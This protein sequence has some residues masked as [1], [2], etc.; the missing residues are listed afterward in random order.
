VNRN[1]TEN[2]GALMINAPLVFS[3][4]NATTLSQFKSLVNPSFP[5]LPPIDH[6]P[7]EAESRRRD[8]YYYHPQPKTSRDAAAAARPRSS[9][10]K[11]CRAHRQTTPCDQT[12]KTSLQKTPDLKSMIFNIIEEVRSK[13]NSKFLLFP[14]LPEAMDHHRLRASLG[15]THP[16][17]SWGTTCVFGSIHMNL[18]LVDMKRKLC[19]T[20]KSSKTQSKPLN[21]YLYLKAHFRWYLVSKFVGINLVSFEAN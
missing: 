1:A 4:C 17:K 19:K 14:E 20:C 2:A 10:S 5:Q 9:L 3:S 16:Q 11:S 8:L 15:N 6:Q 18:Q 13:S 21:L 7:K 12:C